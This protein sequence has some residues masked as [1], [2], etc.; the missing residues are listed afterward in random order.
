MHINESN[1]V[2]VRPSL[3]LTERARELTHIGAKFQ[4]IQKLEDCEVNSVPLFI[5]FFF[6]E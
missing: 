6:L 1:V 2:D 3:D 5:K 4:R